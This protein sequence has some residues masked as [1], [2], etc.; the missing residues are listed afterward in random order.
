MSTRRSTPRTSSFQDDVTG[1]GTA[2]ITDAQLV[3]LDVTLFSGETGEIV[4]STAYD[5]DLATVLPVSRWIAGLPRDRR[6]AAVRRPRAP[7]SW[8]PCRPAAS[9]PRRPPASDSPRTS[10]RSPSSTCT[11]STCRRRTGRL[12]FNAARGLPTVVRAPDGRPGVIVPDGDAARR[13]WSCRPSSRATARSSPATTPVRVH[14]T[15]RHVGRPHG[16]RHHVGH[17]AGVRRRSTQ[18]RPAGFAEALKGQTVGSQVLVVVPP[19][20]GYGDKAQ[21]GDPRGLDARLRD[22]HPRPRPGAAR[23]SAQPTSVGTA[24]SPDSR[25]SGCLRTRP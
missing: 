8:S 16:L 12:V 2:I 18:C 3:A 23:R 13:T 17:R 21:G 24:A 10:P 5:G 20:Q 14:Y 22:R 7:A 1:D 6:R 11:R 4:V 15:G 9:R 19:D 25:M